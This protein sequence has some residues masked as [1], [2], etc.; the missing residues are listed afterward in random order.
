MRRFFG[1]LFISA[2]LITA[3]YKTSF[4]QEVVGFS[5]EQLGINFRQ[6]VIFEF[7]S[8]NP[9]QNTSLLANHIQEYGTKM[10]QILLGGKVEPQDAMTIVNEC[11]PWYAQALTR[12]L[13]GNALNNYINEYVRKITDLFSQYKL[14]LD[15]QSNI[16]LLS[17]NHLENMYN[18]LNPSFY[19]YQ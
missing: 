3:S 19:N 2:F 6:I 4:A 5:A 18:R 13:K 15:A 11:A 1:L 12:M 7:S 17:S 14:D 9:G 16:V 10:A 8:R